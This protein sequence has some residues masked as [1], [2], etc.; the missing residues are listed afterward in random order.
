[1][2]FFTG[3]PGGTQTVSNLLP[4][5]ENN[6]KEQQAAATGTYGAVKNYHMNNLSDNP[7]DFDAFAAPE[8]RKFNEEIIPGLS[9]QFAGMGSGGLDSSSFRN[10][11]VSAG[12]SLSERLGRLRAELRQNSADRLQGIGNEALQNHS[13]Q[14]QTPG[15]EGIAAPLISGALT[16]VAGPAAGVLGNAA[17]NWVKESFK[18]KSKPYGINGATG[19]AGPQVRQNQGIGVI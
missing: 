7:A 12:E 1:M 19:S 8:L 10:A 18:G 2:S 11:A 14:V 3:S 16:A 15:S 4:E 17:A 5:Q 13:T 9:E 6:F